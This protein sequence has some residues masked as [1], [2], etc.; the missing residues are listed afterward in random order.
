MTTKQGSNLSP[1]D[2]MDMMSQM[3]S[4]SKNQQGLGDACVEMMSSSSIPK[5]AAANSSSR[6]PR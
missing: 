6:C 3:I 2:C 1:E 4:Q 5:A